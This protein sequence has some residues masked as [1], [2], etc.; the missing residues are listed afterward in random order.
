[1][2]A[3][4]E[5]ITAITDQSALIRALVEIG[6]AE[7]KIE[8]CEPPK[9]LYGY[10]GDR[11][12]EVA[13]VIVRR[14]DVGDNS[15]DIGFVR[16][17]DGRFTAIV[18]EFDSKKIG[19]AWKGFLDKRFGCKGGFIKDITTRAASFAALDVAKS[20]GFKNTRR[21]VKGGQIQLELRR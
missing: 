9:H 13:H 3:F 21:T 1:M 5:G 15:N 4:V 19:G 7:E 10:Q 20:R 11:R 2:S 14:R 8:I 18:S 16:G 6:F 17:E 12:P